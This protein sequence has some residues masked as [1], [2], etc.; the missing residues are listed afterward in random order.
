MARVLVADD[1]T[2]ILQALRFLLMDEAFPRSFT[3]C[4]TDVV[5]SLR[6]LPH[7]DVVLLA[8]D[9]ARRQLA[10]VLL[11]ELDGDGVHELMDRLQVAIGTIHDRVI[12]TYVRTPAD[13]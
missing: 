7:P 5:E 11:D 1:Q 6:R 4:L 8:C 9:E 12:S 10:A 3:C 2:D 13:R